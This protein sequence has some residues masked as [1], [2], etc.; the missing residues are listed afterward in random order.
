MAGHLASRSRRADSRSASP[1]LAEVTAR[2]MQGF[3]KHG[4]EVVGVLDALAVNHIGD[5]CSVHLLSF[6]QNQIT[7]T[8][9]RHGSALSAGQIRTLACSDS[10]IVVDS[11]SLTGED[12]GRVSGA[13]R[14]QLGARVDRPELALLGHLE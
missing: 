9:I 14:G 12:Q 4:I 13:V 5:S 8:Q 6:A 11:R 10:G 2:P 7:R 1:T 3:A